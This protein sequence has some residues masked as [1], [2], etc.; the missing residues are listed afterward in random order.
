M[1]F[2]YD[3]SQAFHII[4]IFQF[5]GLTLKFQPK[6]CF[7]SLISHMKNEEYFLFSSQ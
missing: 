5:S 6:V 3:E 1:N 7:G 2:W 4:K